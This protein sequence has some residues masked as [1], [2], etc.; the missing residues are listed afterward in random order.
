MPFQID[1]SEKLW[2]PVWL[3]EERAWTEASDP[4]HS[5]V[6]IGVL[7]TSWAQSSPDSQSF[8]TCQLTFTE[9]SGR[10][11]ESWDAPAR[12]EEMWQQRRACSFWVIPRQWSGR[13]VFRGKL[14]EEADMR[15]RVWKLLEK[16]MYKLPSLCA[17]VCRKDFKLSVHSPSTFTR[18]VQKFSSSHHCFIFASSC[19]A[20]YYL[21]H[22]YI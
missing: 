8:P 19:N 6:I 22:L 10:W 14:L 21:L 15:C 4:K 13:Q 9:L 20:L 17:K 1:F 11:Q 16:R 5:M 3:Q 7:G 12:V 2:K 18:R